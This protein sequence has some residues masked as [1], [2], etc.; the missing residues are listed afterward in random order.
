VKKK[1]LNIYSKT[2]SVGTRKINSTFTQ[3]MINDIQTMG[4]NWDRELERILKIENLIRKIEKLNKLSEE[5]KNPR[6]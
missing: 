2:V 5:L 1:N 4:S 6:F 3:E